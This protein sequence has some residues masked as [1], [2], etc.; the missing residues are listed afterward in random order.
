MLNGKVEPEQQT[1]LDTCHP[2]HKLER[3]FLNRFGSRECS[4]IFA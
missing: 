2:G 1:I 4:I 3:M